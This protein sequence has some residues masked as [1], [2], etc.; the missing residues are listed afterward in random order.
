[1]KRLTSC[2]LLL[3]ISAF[4]IFAARQPKEEV[5]ARMVDASG[6]NIAGTSVTRP[7]E[8]QIE[9]IQFSGVTTGKP[10]LRFIM[11]VSNASAV[12]VNMVTNKEGIK[13]AVFSITKRDDQGPQIIYIV[14]LEEVTVLETRDVNGSTD[15]TLK[16]VRIG[17]TYF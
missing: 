12:L 11:P 17:T 3:C 7:F 9:V 4:F 1:M 16:A 8:K 15:V 14:R 2:S 10:E 6:Q 5:F 13:E